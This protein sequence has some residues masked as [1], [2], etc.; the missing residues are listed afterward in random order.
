[1]RRATQP[2]PSRAT[3]AKSA[4]AAKGDLEDIAKR[5]EEL[6]KQMKE[7]GT[8]DA[9]KGEALRKEMG[10]KLEKVTER[11]MKNMQRIASNPEVA[12]ALEE[13][14]RKMPFGR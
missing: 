2:K 7:L 5:M 14:M 3:K 9:E 10:G 12:A 13:T 1:M 8:P 11:M 6:Q 4:E